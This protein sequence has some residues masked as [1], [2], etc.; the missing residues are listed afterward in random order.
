M[1]IPAYSGVHGHL[2]R[3]ERSYR[4]AVQG[5]DT[6]HSRIVSLRRKTPASGSPANEGFPERHAA[7]PD[8][9]VP[10]CR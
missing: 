4:R 5:L 2:P 10:A 7:A 8:L 6:A 1:V 9:A 3:P